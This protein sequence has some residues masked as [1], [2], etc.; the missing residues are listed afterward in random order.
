MYFM[1]LMLQSVPNIFSCIF[2][3]LL[4]VC[5]MPRYIHVY[6]VCITKVAV[7]L[8]PMDAD[9]GSGTSLTWARTSLVPRPPLAVF[10]AA[11]AVLNCKKK[12]CEL[13]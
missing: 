1:H 8:G 13:G 12:C 6:N 5:N 2:I 3:T 11:V 9:W 7:S 4:C 10:I